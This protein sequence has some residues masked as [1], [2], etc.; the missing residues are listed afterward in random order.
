MQLNPPFPPELLPTLDVLSSVH[1]IS[2]LYCGGTSVIVLLYARA[3][4][5]YRSPH[6]RYSTVFEQ[7]STTL[8]HLLAPPK[9]LVG[10]CSAG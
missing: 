9:S 7:L 10:K 8:I 2:S 4:R 5:N 6:M 1:T 3:E